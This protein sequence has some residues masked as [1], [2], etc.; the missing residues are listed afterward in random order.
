MFRDITEKDREIFLEMAE[1][2]YSSDAVSH[3]IERHILETT[4]DTAL[5]KSP[6]IRAVIIENDG[7]PAGFALL[8]FSY[9]TEVGGLVVLLEDIY[10]SEA[11][12]GRGLGK[13]FLQFMENEYPSAKRYRLEVA[14]DNKGAI[15]LY[16]KAGYKMLDYV[17]MVKDID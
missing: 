16:S 1:K 2:F 12:R 13:K 7:T 3:K 15:D 14:K 4:F 6:F 10:I 5:N 8:A 11:C 9:A 17:Q